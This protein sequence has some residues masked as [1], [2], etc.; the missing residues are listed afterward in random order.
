MNQA[1]AIAI[2]DAIVTFDEALN[3]GVNLFAGIILS[4]ADDASTTTTVVEIQGGMPGDVLVFTGD[5]APTAM[6][7]SSDE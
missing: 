6:M 7:M 3:A 4:D 1:P 5:M 2:Q